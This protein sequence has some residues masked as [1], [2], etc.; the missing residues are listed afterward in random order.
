[1][2]YATRQWWCEEAAQEAMSPSL[3]LWLGDGGALEINTQS[4]TV[5]VCDLRGCCGLPGAND[6][7]ALRHRDSRGSCGEGG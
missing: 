7:E 6:D 5:F 2:V 3:S 1:M 4:F